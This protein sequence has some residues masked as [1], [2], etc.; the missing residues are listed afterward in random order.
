[1]TTPKKTTPKKTAPRKTATLAA[2]QTSA[3]RS[4]DGKPQVVVDSRAALR[5]W[6][7]EHHAT[8]SG[9]W[10][11]TTKRSAGG[12]VAWDDIVEE[13]LCFGWIDSLPKKLDERRT[14]LRLTPRKPRS[15]WSAKNKGHVESLLARGLMHEA[16]L[17]V[18]EDAKV[19]GTW[20]VLDDASALVVPDDLAVALAAH[21]AARAHFDAFPRSARRGILEWL[22]A[23]KRPA[24]RAA[25]VDE[26][27]RLAQ[28]NRRANSWP[29]P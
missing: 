17:A 11:V 27:A 18:V 21:P 22:T 10:I 3:D 8:S 13:A 24:T 29:R 12:T 2:T 9:A 4:D 23:A 26:I 19:R 15:A 25:R 6:L 14:M 5:A 28:E 7:L 20:N 1:M 16:G